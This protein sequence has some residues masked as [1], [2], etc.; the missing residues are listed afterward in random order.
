M[1]EDLDDATLSLVAHNLRG[2][3]GLAMGASRTVRLRW[4]E[5]DDERRNELLELAERGMARVD[6]AVFGIARGLPAEVIADLQRS[7]SSAASEPPQPEP[8]AARPFPVPDDEAERLAALRRYDVLDQP[9]ADD[10]DAVVRLAAHLTGAPNAVIN[11]IDAERQWQAAAFGVDRGEVRREQSM[12]AGAVVHRATV[13]VA[14]SRADERYRDSPFV[15]GELGR[16]RLYAAAPLIA[17]VQHVVG[18]ICVF[19]DE[20]RSL[21]PEQLAA[22]EDLARV[23]T[24]LFEERALAAELRDAARWQHELIADLERERRRNEH[25]LDRL[26]HEHS[27]RA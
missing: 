6:D 25:L 14:D 21:A 13:H 11:L 1:P 2:A 26:G 23:V 18:T 9:P 16:I 27:G 8:A 15:T 4:D 7:F 17:P 3:I 22:L 24:S 20:P 19:G 12:C 5:L 10:L